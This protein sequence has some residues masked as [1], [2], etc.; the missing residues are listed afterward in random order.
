M[1][2]NDGICNMRSPEIP[3]ATYRLQFNR[4]FTFADAS[5]IV[6]YLSQ[7]GISH[8]YASP[9]LKARAGSLHGYDIVDHNALNPEIG[10]QDTFDTFTD[11]LQTYDMGQILDLVPN[12]MAV[13]GNDNQWW[14]DVL[15]N[16]QAS[17]YADYFDILWDPVKTE[18]RNKVL[19]AFLG[20]HY[21][22]VL[23]RGELQLEY[24][25]YGGV[26]AVHYFE[27]L[28]PIDPRTY[29]IILKQVIT[30]I[31]QHHADATTL[32]KELQLF[33][34]LFA[35]LP[36]RNNISASIQRR[37]QV[38]EYRNN[39]V[40]LC[41]QH[42]MLG[43]LIKQT[44]QRFNG[45][46][47]EPASFNLIHQLLEEQA[48]RL[49][50][51]LVAADEIN[52]R[53]FFDINDLAGIRVENSDVFSATHQLVLHLLST[54]QIDGLRI[55]HPDGL[56][57]P[58]GYY[59]HLQHKLQQILQTTS[60]DNI[61][62]VYVVVEKILAGYE[63]LPAQWPVS[64][65]TGYDVAAL[66][67]GL[68]IKPESEK[69]FNSI[70]TRFIAQHT[71]FDE[72]VYAS[73]KLVI[74]SQLSSEL[75]VLATLL[76]AITEANRHTR[77]F[78]YHALRDALSEIVVCFPVYRT[79][80]SP[81]GAS[82]EDQRYV[83][84]AVTQ[85]K[86]LSTAVD[87]KIFDFIRDILLLEYP[88][89]PGSQL[90][91]QVVRFAMRF[92]QYTAPVMAKGMEDTALYIYNRLV[93]LNDV[94]FDPRNFGIS[95]NAFHHINLQRLQN[96]PHAMVTTSTHDSKRGEDV[97]A[98]INVLSEIPEEWRQHL[99]RWSRINRRKKSMI[100]DHLA[101]SR[102]DEYLLYQTLLGAW[103]LGTLDSHGMETLRE[104][105]K[106]YMLKA[107]REA[108]VSTSWINPNQEYE[109]G[110]Q[111]FVHAL[112][113]E[114]EHNA[115]LADFHPFQQRIARLGLY[116][117][118]SQTLLKLTIPGVPDIYQGNDLWAFNLV[119]PDNRRPVDYEYRQSLLGSLIAY[120]DVNDDLT[121][122]TRELLVQID[123]GRAK[124]YVAWKTL[125]LRR[126]Y[127]E[128]FNNGD[129][130]GLTVKGNREDHICAF[131]RQSADHTMIA[132]AARWFT[133]LIADENDLPL[134]QSTWVDTQ[135]E[136]AGIGP[137]EKRPDK[138]YFNIFTGES[139]YASQH[140][141]K[142]YF[143]AA[144]LF[145]AFS[146]ALLIEKTP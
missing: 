129:Y 67:N 106:S 78:T 114:P 103:P 30:H 77:D 102:N 76:D 93:S 55:D 136:I 70:Y 137:A 11:R 120:C 64:G 146:V 16:G 46:P 22:S 57:D 35:S 141:G 98:R 7:L 135:I 100:D 99:G 36:H 124:L 24:D 60:S 122:L 73:K 89:A 61:A 26:F 65:T 133:Q 56:Y 27:H 58:A 118:L 49:A 80:V 79:Y 3:T 14:L 54:G 45:S 84:W 39:L 51:W 9:C 40:M 112:L 1:I 41:Q 113:D 32:A 38:D 18:L 6:P 75:T 115:F 52:Y 69:R 140:N 83:D 17:A 138:V 47:G 132:A 43:D 82:E 88:A 142:W 104:R 5:N 10:N 139:V 25:A 91:N 28:F 131:A 53:R 92:Q 44:L 63:H 19:L 33:V 29:P 62:P 128:L 121:A 97:R 107:I 125:N 90:H 119:D 144:D 96:W 101:P 50:Y 20:D 123:D 15:E 59:T 34:E 117:S 66:L 74:A 87:V 8:V 71:S 31:E 12:H 145:N 105:I 109:D 21:G 68:F 130:I 108:K 86:K 143:K 23:E 81:E 85:A 42:G 110:V 127:P 126:Q 72:I 95:C 2:D 94:G 116:N 111:K 4:H 37:Q 48:Y 134:G 13:G